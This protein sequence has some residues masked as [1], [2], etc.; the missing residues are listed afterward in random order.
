YHFQSDNI[1]IEP[2]KQ[3]TFRNSDL[4]LGSTDIIPFTL[5]WYRGNIRRGSKVPLFPSFGTEEDYGWNISWGY[6]YGD[7]ESQYKGGFAPKLAT[8]L[9]VLIGR[10]ENWYETKNYGTAKLDIT[11]LL[12]YKK[13]SGTDD[14]W[15]VEYTHEYDGEYG[16]F[17]LN[18]RNA[19]Y[20]MVSSLNDI[21]DDYDAEGRFDPSSW[22][23]I[24][25]N[26][27][28][29]SKTMTFL[30][31]DSDLKG[32][33]ENKDI[34]FKGTSKFAGDENAY[35]L[36]ASDLID[37]QNY[38]EQSNQ[39]LFANAALYKD[40]ERYKIGGYYKYLFDPVPGSNSDTLQS[41]ANDFGVEIVDKKYNL[42]LKYDENN[43]DK[44]RVLNSWERDPN[45]NKRWLGTSITPLA[46][47]V[48]WTVSQYDIYDNGRLDISAGNYHLAGDFKFKTGYTYKWSEEELSLEK[49]PF[50]SV[51]I[52]GNERDKEYNRYEN[53]IYSD[54][55]EDK[56][57]LEIASDYLKFTFAGGKAEEEFWYRKDTYNYDTEGEGSSYYKYINHSDFYEFSAGTEKLSLGEFGEIDILGG[58]RYDEYTKGYN[59]YTKSY[60]SGSD[61][62][63]RTRAGLNYRT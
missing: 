36:I 24:G 28:S 6:L 2:D 39:S 56:G 22:N 60:A 37:G 47:Y 1:S 54:I 61:S 14:R 21:I 26:R 63:L 8:D 43:G 40:N 50:R 11:D 51:V 18:L 29:R 48:P 16:N 35:K 41:K 30:T 27:P 32:I 53:V 17:N 13:N 34:T 62:T 23:Y 5:P 25:Q 46:D 49:D 33:G 15:N 58:V 38:F 12:I 57:Y 59:P 19:T 52:I 45:L 42:S 9:G 55:R 20:N 10:W 7:R 3:I 31:L 44:Y 4:Y